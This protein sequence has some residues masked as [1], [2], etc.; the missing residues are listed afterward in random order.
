MAHEISDF[1]SK[2][3]DNKIIQTLEE[4]SS[5]LL[6]L[7]S[8]PVEIVFPPV[9]ENDLKNIDKIIPALENAGAKGSQ[10]QLI[11]A[12]GVHLNVS[13]NETNVDYFKDR[14]VA[15]FL[16]Q[17]WLAKKTRLD[18]SRILSGYN[19]LYPHS[20]G[21]GLMQKDF[22]SLAVLIDFY[23]SE[24]P[25]RNYA[26]DMYP[27]WAHLKPD[28][29]DDKDQKVI[30]ARPT[31]HYRLPDCKLGQ[32]GWSFSQEYQWWQNVE[33]LAQDKEKLNAIAQS[34]QTNIKSF[35]DPFGEKWLDILARD[36]GYE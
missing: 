28:M 11:F 19:R 24:I 34:Y 2:N 14:L 27:L 4:T 6:R 22:D 10:D 8:V 1:A 21:I 31:F 18:I 20:F 9:D 30:K 32:N 13:T 36:F 12:F 5:E 23:K 3:K 15:F 33:K 26:L 35:T 29:L 25:D 16:L 17:Y 7:A